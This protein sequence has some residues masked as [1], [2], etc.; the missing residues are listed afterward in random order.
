[1][2]KENQDFSIK[3]GEY[4]L[5]NIT[6]VE[7]DA[8]ALSLDNYTIVWYVWRNQTR[9]I[10]K[11]TDDGIVVT[12]ASAWTFEIEVDTTDTRIPIGEYYHEARVI[13]S[14]D[15]EV[16]VFTGSLLIEGGQ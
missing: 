14:N 9:M 7:K 1:M 3:R 13:D 4:R 15:N 12:D 6:T 11:T 8:S 16:V 10:T 5:L 2:A